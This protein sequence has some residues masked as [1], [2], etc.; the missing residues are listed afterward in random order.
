MRPAL[1]LGTPGVGA[2]RNYNMN[3]E[4]NRMRIKKNSL[5]RIVLVLAMLAGTLNA[6]CSSV[7]PAASESLPDL[8]DYAKR[9]YNAEEYQDAILE[10]QK[11]TYSSRATE[12]EDDVLFYLA[13][14]YYKSGQYLLALDTYKRLVR[15]MPGTSYTR[16][17]YFNIAMCYYNMS[18]RWSLDQE[19][20]RLAIQ[21]FQIFID[22]YPAPDSAEIADQ[23]A[24]LKAHSE[25]DTTKQYSSLLQKVKQQ[26][27]L[28]DTLRMAENH[29]QICREKLARKTFETAE[30]YVRL[31]AYKAAGVYYD[32]VILGYS[33][34]PYYEPALRGKIDALIIRKKW[35]E[36]LAAIE[37][38]EELFP[39]K[40]DQVKGE[41]KEVKEAL[42]DSSKAT[43]S[44]TN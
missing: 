6:G 41:H 14:S 34:S 12:Y 9:L 16:T 36:A 38:Y 15:N 4:I 8:F 22:G 40:R 33:D 27:G 1:P 31:R 28:L 39:D 18:P 23:I 17:V 20:S 13:Q 29:I 11:L 43:V 42:A 24:E 10:L 5:I 3:V 32:E 30:Q 37:K 2:L 19:Y 25:K 21:Q 35:D 7:A 26:Y 44:N